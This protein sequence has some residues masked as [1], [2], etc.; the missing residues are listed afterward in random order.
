MPDSVV[1]L[2]YVYVLVRSDLP[3]ADQ[4]VQVGHACLEAGRR[5]CQPEAASH[6][7]VLS[8]RSQAQLRDAV[9]EAEAMGI[10]FALFEEPDDGMGHSAACT[11]PITGVHRPLFRRFRLW[12]ACAFEPGHECLWKRAAG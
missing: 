11:E 6:L 2:H 8:V 4:L 3:L 5:F 1:A 10:R 12:E 7:V 9:R